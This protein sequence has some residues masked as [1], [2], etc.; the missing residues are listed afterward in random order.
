MWWDRACDW[1]AGMEG[2]NL[3]RKDGLRRQGEGVLYVS[4]QLQ[5]MK[6]HLEMDE[7][8]IET[9]CIGIKA[10]AERQVIL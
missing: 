4:D 3:Y 6:L 8:M 10:R 9:L 1:N 7:E 5:S 2:Y